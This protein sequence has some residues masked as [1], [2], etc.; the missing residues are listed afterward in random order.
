[1]LK[2]HHSIKSYTN[3]YSFIL[4]SVTAD[5][6]VDATEEAEHQVIVTD[7]VQENDSTSLVMENN[8]SQ[9]RY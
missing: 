8:V 9:K 6:S 7:T 1:M 4:V 3:Y 2:T 5:K